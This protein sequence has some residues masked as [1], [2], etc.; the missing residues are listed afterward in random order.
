MES[1]MSSESV[2]SEERVQWV[3]A[4]ENNRQLEERYDQWANEYDDNL[5]DDFGYVM[6][7]M[8]AETFA[9][10]VPKDGKVLDAG[11]GTGLVGVELNKLG[12]SDIEAMDLSRGMLEVAGTKNVYGA[13]HQKVM[14]EPLG[15]ESGTFDAI[16]GVGVLTLGHAPAHSLDELVRVTKPGGV[17]AFTLRPDVYA[18][19]GFRE[20]QEQ[21]VSEGKWELA[22]VSDRFYGMPKG[23]PDV[24]FQVWVYRVKA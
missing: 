13:L 21:L 4:S 24:Q 19:N 15:F 11:A 16:I 1:I 2:N 23:E 14:G 9:R 22:E 10:F 12:Y 20:K 5:T 8:A 7:R 3:Y 18:E 17:V 6:P